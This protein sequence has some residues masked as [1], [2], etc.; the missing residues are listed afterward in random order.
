MP[1]GEALSIQQRH[2]LISPFKDL[3]DIAIN[4]EMC[5][6]IARKV[7]VKAF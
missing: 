4:Q 1:C 7:V 6:S 3:L 2:A 5:C